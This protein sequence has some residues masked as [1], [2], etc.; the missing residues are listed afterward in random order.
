LVTFFGRAKKVTRLPAGTG[1]LDF[2]ILVWIVTKV[3]DKTAGRV[4]QDALLFVQTATKSKQKRPF[5]CGGHG[6]RGRRRLFSP[7]QQLTGWRLRSSE[8]QRPQLN[9]FRWA[10]L[11]RRCFAGN[12]GGE[13]EIFPTTGPGLLVILYSIHPAAPVFATT[14]QCRLGSGG[15]GIIMLYRKGKAP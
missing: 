6:I 1:E 10:G 15:R 2:P 9:K 12:A 13:N 8:R 14:G 5:S 11:C 4:P 3:K 7:V